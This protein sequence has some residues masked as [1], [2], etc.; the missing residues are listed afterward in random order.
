M[1]ML[2]EERVK[3]CDISQERELSGTNLECF[4]RHF[5]GSSLNKSQDSR[6]KFRIERNRIH[7]VYDVG[8]CSKLAMLHT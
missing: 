6:D 7:S 3:V 4:S 5:P 8:C 2:A 1:S